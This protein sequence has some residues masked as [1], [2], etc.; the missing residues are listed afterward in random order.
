M[1]DLTDRRFTYARVLVVD[2]EPSLN[3]LGSVLQRLGI[4]NIRG[5]SDLREVPT[6]F[7]EFDPDLVTV[8]LG[9]SEC[10]DFGILTQLRSWI[11]DDSFLPILV[12]TSNGDVPVKEQALAA[13]ATDFL[14]KPFDHTE[15]VARVRSLLETRFIR[16]ALTEQRVQLEESVRRRTAG[17]E[18][19]RVELLERLAIAAE[20]REANQTLDLAR[21]VGVNAGILARALELPSQTATLIRQAAPLHDIGKVGVPDAVLLKSG[22]LSEDELE[23]VR[24]HTIIGAQILAGSTVPMLQLAEQIALTHHERWDGSGYR[25]LEAG[26][27]PLPSRIIAVIDVFDALTHER[28]YKPAWPVEQALEEIERGIGRQFDPEVAMTFLQLVREGTIV[29]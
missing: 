10:D 20:Y 14:P 15:A 26:A 12:L 17:L 24:Q 29:P 13:G 2:D 19:A 3:L 21:R 4:T 23:I 18:E 28:A 25:G 7:L 6:L 9:L 27:I 11:P 1:P 16:L 8:D 5:T 22:R